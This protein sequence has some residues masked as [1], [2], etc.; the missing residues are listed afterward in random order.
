LKNLLNSKS[1]TAASIS[2]LLLLVFS[3]TLMASPLQAQAQGPG[4]QGYGYYEGTNLQDSGSIPLPAGVTPD[5]A[6]DSR[7]ALS[8]RPNPVGVNQVILVNL[9]NEPPNSVTRYISGYEVTITAPDGTTEVV[10]VDSY[11]AD[12]TAWFEYVVDQ[13]GTWTLK[14][15]HPGA[16]W[17]A[18]NYTMPEG[19][20]RAGFTENYPKSLYERP[21]S[22]LEQSLIVQEEMV[23]SWPPIPLP[24]DYWTRPVPYENREWWAILGNYPWHGLGDYCDPRAYALWD[25]LYPDT[26]RKWSGAYSF[27]PWVQAPET[28]HI[29]W[30]R[31]DAASG[32]IGGDMGLESVTSS[33]NAPEII[34]AGR[35][36]NAISKV[37]NGEYQSVWT[38]TD[39][40][41]GEVIW[42][43]TG[44][45]APSYI[46]YDTGTIEIPGAEARA[47]S[48]VS[49]V[50][51]GGN[52]LQKFDPSTGRMT[53]D[54][55]IP[56]FT[57]TLYYMNGYALSVQTVDTTGGPGEPGTPTAGIYRL[58]NWTT[59]GTAS[60]FADRIVSNITWP[61]A[62]LGPYGGGAGQ[63]LDFESG[64]SFNIREANFFDLPDM[65]YPYV[66]I[67]YDN[68][69]GYRFGTRIQAYNLLTGKME[70]DITVDETTYSGTTNVADHGKLAVLVKEGYFMVFD[71]KSGKLLFKTESMGYPWDSYAFGAY[72]I[73]SAYGMFFRMGYGGIYAFDW[74]D[75]SIVW[76]YTAPAPSQYETPYTDE[77]GVTGYSWNAGITIADGKI[78]A[79]NT[80]HTPTAPITRGWGIHCINATTG[81]G[82]WHMWTPG[83]SR[84]A[85]GYLAV[86]CSDGY[87]YVYGKGKSATTVSAPQTTVAKGTAVLIEGTV[88]DQSPA[89]PGTPCISK[90][91]MTTM[92]QYLHKQ[93]PIDG[94]WHDEAITGVPVT[95]TAIKSD[96]TY[97][98]LGTTTTE[99]YYGTFGLKWTPPDEGTYR[100]IASFEG[101]DSY[102]SSGA[103]TY[104]SVGPAPSP[105][106]PIEPEP[107]PTEAPLITTEVAIIAAVAVVAVIGIVA[108]WVLRKRK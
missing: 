40:R 17:P 38:C 54:R 64:M 73:G 92:M 88:L 23:Y 77:N 107:E 91:S 89:Q 70:W 44:V 104:V 4:P 18:G 99:G 53:L 90:D 1:K 63:M 105:S 61:R 13:V 9:W 6:V 83:S 98:D 30:K 96:G 71:Q 52:T 87:M 51:I 36:Y 55:E 29:A 20:A 5:V 74:N 47:G 19:T 39:I 59:L 21:S 35:A 31:L 86:G 8:F 34:Y 82:I 42:E 7:I 60:A 16:Y 27:I 75:G 26:N 85:D 62:N 72:S 56:S 22:T 32:I 15:E 12:S 41:T 24:T 94:I 25:E 66:D 43:Q 10:T 46:E 78:Y 101:D 81:E 68:A 69:S 79:Y 3:I 2:L 65:G 76:K 103:A 33:G 100:I 45:S 14:A 67:T 106:G 50:R 28:A 102:G 11:Q 37:F 95:L 84:V 93:Q 48:S 58:I 80:E 49:L 97:I 108:Y 57:T